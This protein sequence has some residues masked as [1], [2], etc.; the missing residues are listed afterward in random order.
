MMMNQQKFGYFM[1][2]GGNALFEPI[3]PLLDLTSSDSESEEEDETNVKQLRKVK[4]DS[5][6]LDDRKNK[7][8]GK[9]GL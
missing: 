2:I 1:N 5:S 8:K 4:S 9:K 3:N 7:K 6:L